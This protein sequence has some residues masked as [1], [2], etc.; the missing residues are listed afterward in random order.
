MIGL[1]AISPL[2]FVMFSSSARDDAPARAARVL[3]EALRD[4]LERDTG[5][6]VLIVET[7]ISWV[8]LDGR[9]AW[10][11]KKPVRLGFLDFGELETRRHYCFEELRLNRRL[12]PELYEAVVAIHGRADDPRLDSNEHADQ[13]DDDPGGR[14]GREPHHVPGEGP[15]IEY[16]LR[17]KQFASG[18][19]FSE[20]LMAGTLEPWHIDRFAQRIAGFHESAARAGADTRFGS[21]DEIGAT[22]AQVLDGLDAQLGVARGSSLRTWLGSECDR[23]CAVFGERRA[24]DWVRECH[25]D[26]HLAN[27]VVLGEQVT[28]FDCI[29]FDPSLRWIDVQSDIAFP[30]MDLIACGR[31][32][33]AY[34]FLD[35]WLQRSGD[36]GG[37]AVLRFNAVYRALV[38]ALVAAIRRSQSFTADGPDYLALAARLAGDRNP[39]LLITHGLSGSGKSYVAQQLLERA[40]AI[41]IRSD[42]ERKRLFGLGALDASATR[43]PGGIYGTGATR[44]T[45]DRLRELA[46]RLLDAGWPVIVDAAFL[47][48]SERAAFAALAHERGVPFAIL[49][50]HAEPKLLRERVQARQSAAADPSEADLAVLERQ[51]ADHDPLS[52]AE[53]AYTIDVDTSRKTDVHGVAGRWFA[54][55]ATR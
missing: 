18:A 19:L 52:E 7:H 35:A 36:Y 31:P 55:A 21:P 15:P 3:V 40:G 29:E 37:V 46:D 14:P 27:V 42:V 39:R 12:A 2:A 28:A 6:P 38:R 8:L 13:A 30:F 24:E 44:R 54:D 43:I 10:K 23:L 11:I 47:R 53:R 9:H 48:A 4:R 49:H 33:L 16:A 25:G 51:L 32:E 1:P 41:R 34:R 45:F 26:L 17:M 22:I 5:R 20:K 50:C